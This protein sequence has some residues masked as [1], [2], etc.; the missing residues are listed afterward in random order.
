MSPGV[1]FVVFF[2]FLIL[3]FWAVREVKE[4]KIAQNEKSQL[5]PLH[6]ISKEYDHDFW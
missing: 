4:Q 3:I 5:H 6:A 2:F 1:F